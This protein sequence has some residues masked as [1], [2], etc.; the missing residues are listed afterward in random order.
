MINYVTGFMFSSDRKNVALITKINPAWQKGLINGV[1]GKIE[2]GETP[3]QAMSR[4]FY[5]E[6]GVHTSPE[7]W[8]CYCVINRPEKYSVNFLVSIDDNVFNT[9]SIEKEIVRVYE[10]NNLPH[11]V[12]DNLR[13]LIPMSIDTNLIFSSPIILEENR[14]IN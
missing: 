3:E 2:H 12:I 5:E 9:R 7:Q 10:V 13:W 14:E 11:N 4:E 1:G 6:T 8:T